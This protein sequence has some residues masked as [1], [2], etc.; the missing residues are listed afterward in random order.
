MTKR[1]KIVITILVIIG[2][3]L[4]SAVGYAAYIYNQANKV[5]TDA[6]EDVGRE[7]E[8]SA[9]R[10]KQVDPVNDHV[11]VLFIGVDSHDESA[12]ENSRSDALILGTFNKDENNVKL[13]SIPRDSYVYIPD[14]GYSTK[15]NHAHAYG[16]PRAT[17]ETVEDFLHVPID[18]YVR[19][20]FKAFV[21]LVESVGGIW[22][23]VPY[24]I[25]EPNSG[26]HRD[27]IHLYPGY[28]HLN[29]EEALALA[30]T[31][32]YD[33]DIERGKRQQEII[34]TIVEEAT[35]VSSL[36]NLDDVIQAI[37]SNLQTNLT[38]NEIRGFL[39]Y[40]VHGNIQIDTVNL[41]GEG[42]YMNDGGWYFQV[43]EAS[44]RKVQ[45]TL[46]N[47][48]DLEPYEQQENYSY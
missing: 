39:S 28:Q 42:G 21:D 46:Q 31:R 33:N 6:H 12:N 43:D 9:L 36:F 11:S 29:G 8:T 16:G 32:K 1:K 5:V 22:Y 35:S 47:H 4:V 15:I 23:D 7:N 44:R 2:A 27:S 37:G 48:L 24:E 45:E 40:G 17:I 3:L 34:K 26:N 14:V 38:M 10:D 25:S 13:L 18:Y 20:N 19:V 41:E 30:R